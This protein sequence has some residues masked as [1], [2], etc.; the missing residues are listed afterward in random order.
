MYFLLLMNIVRMYRN[1]W[2]LD[3]VDCGW[4]D[5]WLDF[6]WKHIRIWTWF[7]FKNALSF[8]FW[9]LMHFSDW[10]AGFGFWFWSNNN[11][12]AVCMYVFFAEKHLIYI[13][14]NEKHLI[15]IICIIY[16]KKYTY[17]MCITVVY[18]N[19]LHFLLVSSV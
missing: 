17:I 19:M 2:W 18:L 6:H 14:V 12:A 10:V 15:Y 16:Q 13:D 5:V 1:L 4:L 11:W 8:L 7:W 9:S 3:D